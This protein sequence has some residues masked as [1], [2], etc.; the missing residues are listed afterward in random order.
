MSGLGLTVAI[1]LDHGSIKKET[2]YMYYNTGQQM[3]QS[4]E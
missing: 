1:I 4:A 2:H 3:A